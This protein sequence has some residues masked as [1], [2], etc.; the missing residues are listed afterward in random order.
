MRFLLLLFFMMCSSAKA[1]EWHVNPEIGSNDNAGTKEKPF[2]TI[3]KAIAASS[4]GDVISLHPADA[5][6]RQSVNLRNKSNLTI[7]GNGVT[8]DGSE[9]LEDSGWEKIESDLFRKRLLKTAMNRHLLIVDGIMERMGRTQS[10]KSPDFPQIE[11]LKERQ[12]RFEEI[13]DKEGWLYVRGSTKKL[14]WSIRVNGLA[15]SGKCRNIT[16]ENL[17]A[18]YFLN[19]GFN[20]HGDARVMR[21]EKI[22]GYDCFD[23]GFSAHDT[24]ECFISNGKFWGNE[25]GIADVNFAETYYRHCEFYKNFH[26]DVL[27]IGKTHELIDCK[28]INS[29]DAKALMAGPRSETKVMKLELNR[30][31]LKTQNKKTPASIRVNGGEL[32][33]SNS[34]FEKVDFNPTGAKLR[35]NNLVVNGEKYGSQP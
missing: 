19:D 30:V 23:E 5:V 22:N 10:S 27:L 6:Y 1:A 7:L 17:N 9:P 24:C 13:D 3:Q 26:V 4:A 12:F 14:Q 33:I 35:A 2:A 16:V 20:L 15:T 18:R 11:N 34:T 8:L 31:S 28:I 21:F 32:T 29:T 25:N